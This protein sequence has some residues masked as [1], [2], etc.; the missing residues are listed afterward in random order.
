MS[1][2]AEKERVIKE[3]EE[4]MTVMG[5]ARVVDGKTWVFTGRYGWLC[6][7][8]PDDTGTITIGEQWTIRQ[9]T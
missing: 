1:E 8:G 4:K 9:K 2:A 3:V 5:A 7:L 6:V